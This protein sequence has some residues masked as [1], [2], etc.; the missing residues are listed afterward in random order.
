MGSLS[1][2]IDGSVDHVSNRNSLQSP[3]WIIVRRFDVYISSKQAQNI[4][5]LIGYRL[6]VFVK[7]P[8]KER[9]I[10]VMRYVRSSF[11]KLYDP[12]T[13]VI[14]LGLATGI[15]LMHLSG[16]INNLICDFLKVRFLKN[17]LIYTCKSLQKK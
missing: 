16:R 10:T 14:N 15:R 11:L 2:E 4:F 1:C 3:G 6:S 7:P 13:V 8:R 17:D 12:D 9:S 5:A